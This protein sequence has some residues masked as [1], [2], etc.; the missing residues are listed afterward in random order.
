VRFSRLLFVVSILILCLP[1]LAQ[2][3]QQA[4]APQ[5]APRDAQAV[6]LV[7]QALVVAGGAAAFNA[8]T[9][10]TAT[11]NITYY[12]LMNAQ[13]PVTISGRGPSEFRLDASLAAGT[14]SI[15]I[16]GA[17][18]TTSDPTGILNQRNIQAP[19]MTGNFVLPYRQ[20]A[21]VFNNAQFSLAY[22]GI[23]QI[24]GHSLYDIRA[25]R[26]LPGQNDPTGSIR[27][28]HTV[29]FFIDSSTLQL[30]MTQDALPRRGAPRIIQY[31]NYQTAS[32][33]LVPL[34]INET[35]GGQ[36]SYTLNLTQINF[37]VGLQDA[38]FDLGAIPQ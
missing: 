31:S 25:I 18:T 14:R 10:Y 4:T 2:Q 17:Q 9:D 5:P 28:F 34:S 27:I 16:N 30:Y 24:D 26:I 6:S 32:G 29:D 38:T 1:V 11:G 3:T 8:I 37:N 23:V 21:A 15:V 22:N 36:Q 7:T 19:M 20:L 33:V 13:G 35:V 12:G